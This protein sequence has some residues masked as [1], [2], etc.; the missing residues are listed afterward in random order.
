MTSARKMIGFV[1]IWKIK[2][3][4][5][6]IFSIGN[7]TNSVRTV[8]IDEVK[9]I[10]GNCQMMMFPLLGIHVVNVWKE[11]NHLHSELLPTISISLSRCNNFGSMVTAVDQM[12]HRIFTSSIFASLSHS[13]GCCHTHFLVSL[14]SV[15]PALSPATSATSCNEY[16]GWYARQ[17]NHVVAWK[18]SCGAQDQPKANV[19]R[20]ERLKKC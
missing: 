10:G 20:G 17:G 11:N 8:V 16:D 14:L 3:F 5:S 1:I 18:G 9:T 7:I 12:E 19:S 6:R 2:C 4:G 15:A 13:N